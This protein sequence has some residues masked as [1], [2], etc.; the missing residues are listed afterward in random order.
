[1]L[2][3]LYHIGILQNEALAEQL[4]V[5]FFLPGRFVHGAAAFQDG[6][7]RRKIEDPGGD[8]LLPEERA[9]LPFQGKEVE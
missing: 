4:F 2:H 1:M 8:R 3:G 5:Q 7:P 9:A 6:F